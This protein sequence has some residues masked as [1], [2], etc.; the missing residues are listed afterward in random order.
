MFETVLSE[1]VFG[2]FPTKTPSLIIF[3]N[4]FIP[5][6]HERFPP[7]PSPHPCVPPSS[8]GL[9]RSSPGLAWPRPALVSSNL[10]VKTGKKENFFSARFLPFSPFSGGRTAPGKSRKQEEKVFFLRYPLICSSP[11][12]LIGDKFGESLGGSQAPRSFWEVPG[13]PRKFPN[14]PR[15]FFGDFPG[16]SLTVQL[17]SNPEVPGSSPNFPGSS[18]TS[19]E[20]S[21][22]GKPDTLS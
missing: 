1:T 3:S 6:K 8:P 21:P 18:R 14:L 20:V 12:L 4:A 17:N 16:S 11:H 10:A 15:K 9:A 19:P 22:F 13:L 7:S 2:P 5:S